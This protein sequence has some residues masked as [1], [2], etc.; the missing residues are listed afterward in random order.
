MKWQKLENLVLELRFEGEVEMSL[1]QG[2]F[3]ERGEVAQKRK[4]IEPFIWFQG[5]GLNMWH[6]VVHSRT[7]GRSGHW[8]ACV[9]GRND[10][11]QG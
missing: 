10:R 2:Y 8:E 6:Y 9:C 7:A 5:E 4:D 1:A 3:G 11:S